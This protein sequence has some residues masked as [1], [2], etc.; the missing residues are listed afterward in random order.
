METNEMTQGTGNLAASYLTPLHL[1]LLLHAYTTPAAWLNPSPAARDYQQDLVEAGLI[2]WSKSGDWFECTSR[3]KAHVNQ[4][5]SLS[6]PEQ[7]WVGADGR[8][9]MD[10]FVALP[11][12]SA[13]D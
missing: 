5:C 13:R 4:L 2:E 8:V 7:A 10:P 9:I 6:F 12:I 3:G 11:G 1:K